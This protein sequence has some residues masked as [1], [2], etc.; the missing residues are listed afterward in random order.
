M[1]L[2]TICWVCIVIREQELTT[3]SVCDQL[4]VYSFAGSNDKEGD[5]KLIF[6]QRVIVLSAF[7]GVTLFGESPFS[8]LPS[9][10]RSKW[11]AIGILS[12]SRVTLELAY[13]HNYTTDSNHVF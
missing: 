7:L 6:S 2:T 4:E 12:Q 13:F 9:N 1:T 5:A 8:I 10:N 11:P 3:R